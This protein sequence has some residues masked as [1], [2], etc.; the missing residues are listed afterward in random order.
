VRRSPAL[1]SVTV[2]VALLGFTAVGPAAHASVSASDRRPRR[3]VVAE[4]TLY[5]SRLLARLVG[6]QARLWDWAHRFKREDAEWREATR[7]RKLR[8]GASAEDKLHVGRKPVSDP[9]AR[10]L[11]RFWQD[12]SGRAAA[13]PE[14]AMNDSGDGVQVSIEHAG[15]HLASRVLAATK[16]PNGHTLEVAAE[17]IESK[18]Q[19]PFEVLTWKGG[20]RG[21]TP[22]SGEFVVRDARGRGVARGD[23]RALWRRA[24]S[25]DG[26][27]SVRTLGL[28]LGE[29]QEL[30][31]DLTTG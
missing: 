25:R 15:P 16:L 20:P 24:R 6:V 30:L 21:R 28:R 11:I 19:V 26:R 3:I 12:R 18:R 4:E 9:G 17:V 29:L 8:G 2:L 31:V 5:I 14:L 22:P 1:A 23:L 7:Y 27:W 13:G 10:W